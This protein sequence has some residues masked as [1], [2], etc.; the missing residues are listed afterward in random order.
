MHAPSVVFDGNLRP[1]SQ[2]ADPSSSSAPKVV[3][4]GIKD[5]GSLR[6]ISIAA[7]NPSVSNGLQLLASV[8]IGNAARKHV[9]SKSAGLLFGVGS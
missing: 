9:A 1:P 3:Q 5:D 2:S 6:P 8:R 4:V 7:N